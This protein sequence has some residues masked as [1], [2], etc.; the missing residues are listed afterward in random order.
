[1]AVVRVPIAHSVLEWAIERT[2]STVE[3]LASTA[4]LTHIR[5]W[6]DGVSQ[7][8]IRQAEALAKKASLP[9][10]LLLLDQPRPSAIPLPDF[11]TVESQTIQQPSVALEQVLYR[12][13][14]QLDWYVEYAEAVGIPPVEYA[15]TAT[16]SEDPEDTAERVRDL[17]SWTPGLVSLNERA[18]SELADAIEAMGI[19]VT[20]NSIVGNASHKPLDVEEFRGF[21]L[22][23]SGYA[24]IFINTRDAKSAQ[25]FSLAHEL[26]HVLL[27]RPG[28]S[29]EQDWK[30]KGERAHRRVETWCNRFAASLLMPRR[31]LHQAISTDEVTLEAVQGAAH[32]LGVSVR[33]LSYR[34]ADLGIVSQAWAQELL[35]QDSPPKPS[36]R[37]GGDAYRNIRSRLGDRLL[38]AMR[39][40]MGTDL[41]SVRDA[42]ELVGASERKTKPVEMFRR[43]NRTM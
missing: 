43:L 20:R 5:D 34:L 38:C 15:G 10:P 31:Y 2:G 3:E 42:L 12:A 24:L 21:T 19:L 13:E 33:A 18:I 7:P 1:M 39:D 22:L 40:S 35:S 4:E 30:P 25:L 28:I 16:L 6:L 37:Q 23:R 8:T 17:L 26:G 27:G 9:Y 14:L 36:R 29:A 41:L 11:R 32:R